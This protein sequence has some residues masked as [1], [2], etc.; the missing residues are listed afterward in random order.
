MRGRIHPIEMSELAQAEFAE[1][2]RYVKRESAHSARAVRRAIKDKIAQL[3]R[4]PESAPADPEALRDLPGDATARVTHA[5][6]FVLRYLYPFR[7][8]D[9]VV[10]YIV[11]IQRAER[12]PPDDEEYT[13]RLLKEVAGLYVRQRS[14]VG[15]VH[16]PF[17]FGAFQSVHQ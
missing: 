13:L 9:R 8:A 15:G 17:A 4:F 6:G 2:I 1:S 3:G 11:S 7:R 14:A 5:S 12:L 10:V 16:V